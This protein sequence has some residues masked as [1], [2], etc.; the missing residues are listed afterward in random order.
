MSTW[1]ISLMCVT[2]NILLPTL[3]WSRTSFFSLLNGGTAGMIWGYFIVWIGYLLVFASM[4]EMASMWVMPTTCI[5]DMLT[6]I[7]HPPL[8]AS[9]IGCLSFPVQGPRGS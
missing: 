5:G 3:T 8:A 2:P 1:E 4:A 6:V 9:T 7:V